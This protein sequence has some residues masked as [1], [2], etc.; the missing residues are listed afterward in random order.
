M[1]DRNYSKQ[2]LGEYLRELRTRTKLNRREF[3]EY[4]GIPLRTVEDWE[5]GKRKI[6]DYL[7]RLIEYKL[8]MENLIWNAFL[9]ADKPR[10]NNI[11]K[12][13]HKW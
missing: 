10:E 3:A 2:E 6:P 13:A 7:L 12:G 1:I 4:F 8:R 9:L 5:Y 11:A